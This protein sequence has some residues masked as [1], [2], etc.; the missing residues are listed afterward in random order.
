MLRKINLLLLSLFV[1]AGFAFGQVGFG[2][3]Q[4]VIKDE[5]T[6]DPIPFVNVVVYEGGIQKGVGR[7]DFDGKFSIASITPG[8]YDVEATFTGYAKM[9]KEGV[10][11]NNN[12]ITFLNDITMT[13]SPTMI[14]TVVVSHYKVPLIDKDGG[15]SGATI[16]HDAIK[17]MAVR[18]ASDIA[19]TVGGVYNDP[20]GGTSIRGGRPGENSTYYYIDG[21]K[22]RGSSNLP[23]NSIEEVSV[24]TGG[25]PANYGDVTGGVI[26]ITTRGPSSTYFGSIEAVTSGFYFK[27]KDKDGYDGKTIGLDKFGYNLL[28]GTISGPLWMKKDSTGKKVKPIMGFFLSANYTDQN[29]PRPTKNGTY[30]IKKEARDFLL[31]NPLRPTGTGTGTYYSANFLNSSDFERPLFVVFST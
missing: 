23:K 24:I 16:T 11:I 22:V 2:S 26:S 18:S 6:G 10:V 25:V 7:T 20:N 30:R 13:N 17:T 3:V 5:K 12:K 19:G 8:K 4:G 1:S 28:E 31:E 27:G 29:D 9:R 14:N 21:I 15:A